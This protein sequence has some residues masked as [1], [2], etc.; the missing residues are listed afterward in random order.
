M[1]KEKPQ[2]LP[3]EKSLEIIAAI[4]I[5]GVI[6]LITHEAIALITMIMQ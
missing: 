2:P 1:K 3:A 4:M 6:V 5:F